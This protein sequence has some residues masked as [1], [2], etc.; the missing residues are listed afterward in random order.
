MSPP[1]P[2]VR[3]IE[4]EDAGAVHGLLTTASLCERAGTT[5]WDPPALATRRLADPDVHRFGAF[6]R[7]ALLGYAELEPRKNHRCRHVAGLR[8][9][10]EGEPASDV[11]L[12]SALDLAWGWLNI[13]RVEFEVPAGDEVAA[14]LAARGFLEEYRKR[15]HRVSPTGASDT[16][17]LAILREGFA[18][19]PAPPAP[20]WPPRAA[21]HAAVL[22]R[23]SQVEDAAAFAATLREPSVRWGTLQVAST[24]DSLWKTRLARVDRDQGVILVAE[25]EGRV[26]GHAGLHPEGFPTHRSAMVGMTVSHA[27]QGRG[28]G[29]VLLGGLIDAARWL[30]LERIGLEVYPDNQRALALYQRFG[31]AL[32]GTRR[33]AAWRDGFIVDSAVMGLL[34]R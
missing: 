1:L 3:P 23:P 30:G 18:P 19:P 16:V 4:P 11:L 14:W 26:V 13:D 24:P 33:A 17:G 2:S 20:P 10:A 28:V 25:Q 5:P 21:A 29:G 27:A 31:F 32:E 22:L 7:G 15:G 8:L 6:S 12:A 34:L 9:V